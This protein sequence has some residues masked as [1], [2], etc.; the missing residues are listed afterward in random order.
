MRTGGVRGFFF[1][2]IVIVLLN[3]APPTGAKIEYCLIDRGKPLSYNIRP[4]QGQWS[5]NLAKDKNK[6][7]V[8]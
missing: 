7:L 4:F 8:F 2:G 1:T 5:V 3:S 6:P